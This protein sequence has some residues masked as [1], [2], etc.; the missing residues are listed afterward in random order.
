MSKETPGSQKKKPVRLEWQGS[1]LDSSP[2]GQDAQKVAVKGAAKAPHSSVLES[3]NAQSWKGSVKIRR[4]VKGRGG[5]P[6]ALLCEFSPGAS[7]SQK[8]ALCKQMKERL[9]CGGTVEEGSVLL[10]VDDFVRLSKALEAFGVR[11]LRGG[12]FS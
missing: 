10:Q 2:Q 4:E 12:G 5:K 7:D 8:Q 11:A 9:G 6:V 1:L 3:E